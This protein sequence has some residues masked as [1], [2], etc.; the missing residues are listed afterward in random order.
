MLLTVNRLGL[1]G[2]SSL[3][4]EFGVAILNSVLTNGKYKAPDGKEQKSKTS[5]QLVTTCT[6]KAETAC[7]LGSKNQSVP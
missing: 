3:V 2:E 1:S 4:M 7:R 6:T 5:Q